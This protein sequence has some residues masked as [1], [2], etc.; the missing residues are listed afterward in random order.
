MDRW[1]LQDLL[2]WH[3]RQHDAELPIRNKD[4]VLECPVCSGLP[5]WDWDDGW[6]RDTRAYPLHGNEWRESGRDAFPPIDAMWTRECMYKNGYVVVYL[7]FGWRKYRVWKVLD[8]P[9]CKCRVCG[10]FRR[11]AA[12]K[13]HHGWERNPHW[14]ET[15][16]SRYERDS[17]CLKCVKKE[18]KAAKRVD[19]LIEANRLIKLLGGKDATSSERPRRS[20]KDAGGNSPRSQIR[21]HGRK[22]SHC[23]V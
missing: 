8:K 11:I 12:H 18:N 6:A 17:I 13:F 4:R 21:A 7:A 20:A 16:Y 2:S 22:T 19:Q 23:S 15:G 3:C 10:K 1:E 9:Y 14:S 5:P